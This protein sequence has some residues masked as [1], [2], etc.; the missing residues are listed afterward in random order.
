MKRSPQWEKAAVVTS[1]WDAWRGEHEYYHVQADQELCN[2]CLLEL[3]KRIEAALY[4][5]THR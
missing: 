5:E 3:T 4:E 2:D 1:A